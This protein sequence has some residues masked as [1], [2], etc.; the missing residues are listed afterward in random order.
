MVMI[1]IGI[2]HSVKRRWEEQKFPYDRQNYGSVMK[3]DKV[4]DGGNGD[5]DDNDEDND[6]H[7]DHDGD[8]VFD[9]EGDDDDKE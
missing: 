7:D 9:E 3:K 8:K 1:I 5:D 4:D 2:R 6:N